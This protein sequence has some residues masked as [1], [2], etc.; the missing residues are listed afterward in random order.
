LEEIGW[1]MDI[2][3]KIGRIPQNIYEGHIKPYL[4]RNIGGKV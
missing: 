2:Y 4:L 3:G 1:L